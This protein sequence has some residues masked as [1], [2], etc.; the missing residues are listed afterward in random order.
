[1]LTE[2]AMYE[3]EWGRFPELGKL[4]SNKQLTVR[5]T[6][7]SSVSDSIFDQVV[8]L[9]KIYA[10]VEDY[11]GDVESALLTSTPS[12]RDELSSLSQGLQWAADRFSEAS[13]QIEE[14]ARRK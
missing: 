4:L 6:G 2:H 3:R 14:R 12:I 1:M 11:S 10:L 7:V 9:L 5:W 13:R 8:R